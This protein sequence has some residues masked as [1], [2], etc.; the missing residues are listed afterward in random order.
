MRRAEW[1]ALAFRLLE[2]FGAIP[3]SLIDKLLSREKHE[4][5]AA[6][7]TIPLAVPKAYMPRTAL[8]QPQRCSVH[9]ATTWW[10]PNDGNG[11]LIC[12]RC[13][14]SPF[15]DEMGGGDSFGITRS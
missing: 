3:M 2:N 9:G 12:D 7:S 15:D 1:E 5:G 11:R 13:H 10:T 4:V 14:P 6:P 8:A